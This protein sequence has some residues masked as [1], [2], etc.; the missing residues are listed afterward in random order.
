MHSAGGE[1]AAGR[2]PRSSGPLNVRDQDG[3]EFLTSVA[4]GWKGWRSYHSW[5]KSR[6]VGFI[7]TISA[8][9]LI[10]SQVLISFSRS[11]AL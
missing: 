10:R 4:S 3:T 11:I 5:L 2:I 8:I 7:E 1:S 6:H 9:F